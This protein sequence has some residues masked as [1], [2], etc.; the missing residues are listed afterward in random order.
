MKWLWICKMHKKNLET[1]MRNEKM[2]QRKPT[3][4]NNLKET[5]DKL[6]LIQKNINTHNTKRKRTR[7]S[8]NTHL[9]QRKKH[10]FLKILHQTLLNIIATDKNREKR[11]TTITV[12]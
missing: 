6:L 4:E 1:A 11:R 5:M 3:A 8:N 9:L 10:K 2:N 7:L 12:N